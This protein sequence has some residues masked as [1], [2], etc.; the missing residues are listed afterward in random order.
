MNILVV[1]DEPKAGNYLLNGLQEL[2]YTVNLARD[3]VD[4]LHLALEHDFDVI[5]LDVMM[6][7]MDG[8]EV[9]RRL[10]KE[11][12]HV[13]LD[14]HPIGKLCA[15]TIEDLLRTIR[16]V[17]LSEMQREMVREVLRQIESRGGAPAGAKNSRGCGSNVITA[18][19]RPRSSAASISRASIAW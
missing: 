11:A 10:R 8:W 9:L 6:P 7:K 17:K 1:E 15:M 3:G 13:L 19:G 12:D 4:G 16:Q 18:G 5:V 14:G 2:G